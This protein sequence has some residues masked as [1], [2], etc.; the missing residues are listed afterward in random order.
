MR[1]TTLIRRLRGSAAGW[2]LFFLCLVVVGGGTY[3]YLEHQR[4][5]REEM[6]ARAE[7]L[8][9]R[10]EAEEE[11]RRL[12]AE[13]EARKKREAEERQRLA[14]LEAQRRAEEE[15]RRLAEE[16]RRRRLE[17]EA[18]RLAALR[19]Q[20]GDEEPEKK[21]E[22]LDIY[23]KEVMLAGLKA[24]NKANEKL[25]KDMVDTVCRTNGWTV[26]K[27][28]LAA[29]LEKEIKGSLSISEF[30]MQVYYDSPMLRHAM[31]INGVIKDI[32]DESLAML[33][34]DKPEL[35]DQSFM[36]ALLSN[37][38]DALLNLQRSLTGDEEPD[39]LVRIL[40][41]WKQL[42]ESSSPEF[43]KK[44]QSLALACALVRPDKREHCKVSNAAPMTM[45][46]VY[47]AFCESAEN[48]NLKTDITKMPATDLIYV[49]NIG[50]PKSEMEWAQKNVRLTQRSWGEA[51]PMIK[52]RMDRAANGVNPYKYYTFAEIK[53][54][55]GICMDQG[56][57]ATN[58]A[59][60]NG[61]PASYLTGDGQLG[62]H[63]WFVYMDSGDSWKSAGGY[64]YTSGKT[65]NPQTGRHVHESLFEMRADKKASGKKLEE[66]QDMI[67]VYRILSSMGLKVPA[68]KLLALA[69]L[70]TPTHPL[71]WVT[72]INAMK[73]ED[74]G[75][76]V[77]QWSELSTLLRKRFKNRQDFLSLADEI[78]DQY[79]RPFKDADQVAKDLR[80]QTRKADDSRSDLVTEALKRQVDHLVANDRL[81]DADRVYR[82]A[83]RD[84][85][86]KTD[87][88]KLVIRQY[89]EFVREHQPGE[90]KK[91]LGVMERMYKSD[92]ETGSTFYFTVK[93]EVGIIKM[94]AGFY[95]EEGDDKKADKLEKA[96]DARYNAAKDAAA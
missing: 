5:A 83:L 74:A 42:W 61:I 50:L 67:M 9:K 43:R 75:T 27:P 22:R 48:K 88:L 19:N 49:V 20:K 12:L 78:D 47:A 30:K 8:R 21:D 24:N 65:T 18:R 68:E 94:I 73:A 38:D 52:Y 91:T 58:T 25:W 70:N 86:K 40:S 76:T 84:Y 62:P 31:A 1:R 35:L 33:N 66:T 54:E 71:P 89:Y 69:R 23:Q 72:T 93:Q 29:T 32:P 11:R 17:E 41:T 55:G 7:E 56:Y 77:A 28:F 16:E 96:A 34:G 6:A 44:Y 85:S 3:M 90:M 37:T 95:R 4:K 2:F 92:V 64:G 60:C 45:E 82:K 87:T 14:R 79:V 10:R 80:S 63:A 57:F 39:E 81:G 51:F 59:R 26:F 53:K 46:E 36:Y 13:E 15:R